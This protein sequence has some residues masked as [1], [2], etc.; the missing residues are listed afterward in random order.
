MVSSHNFNLCL[1]VYTLIV[2]SLKFN[3]LK[4]II[5][6]HLFEIN[7]FKTSNLHKHQ[8]VSTFY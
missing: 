7:T 1:T 4:E 5:I 6:S 2:A 3:L 8:I